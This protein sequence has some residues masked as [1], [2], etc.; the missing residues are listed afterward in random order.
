MVD[1]IS[2]S[3]KDTEEKIKD[4]TSYEKNTISENPE[5]ISIEQAF[6]LS[7]YKDIQKSSN[8]LPKKPQ[9]EILV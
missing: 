1:K 4:N 6:K 9:L 7:T 8:E 5:D 3:L 2:S